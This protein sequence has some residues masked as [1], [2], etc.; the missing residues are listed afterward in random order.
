MQWKTICR[1]L[2]ISGM[3]ATLVSCGKTIT[4][5]AVWGEFHYINKTPL[6]ITIKVKGAINGATSVQH[7]I[8][9]NDS[10]V[11][12][13]SGITTQKTATPNGYLPPLTADSLTVIFKDTL[14]YKEYDKSGPI[15]QN[16]D[17]YTYQKKGRKGL[18]FLF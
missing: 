2:L 18:C 17:S 16:I 14:C 9:P 5:Y 8:L 11:L 3:S 15:L 6:S 7:I 13:T 1:L 12:K 10:I 4:D